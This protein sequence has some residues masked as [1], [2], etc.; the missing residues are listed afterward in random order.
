M[1]DTLTHNPVAAD[2]K[3]RL[4]E[5]SKVFDTKSGPFVALEPMTLDIPEGCFF[6][7]VGPS[8]CGKTTL[9][10]ILAGLEERSGGSLEITAPTKGRPSNSMV[11]QG[12]SLFPWMT[13]FENA[14]YGLRMRRRPAGEIRDVVGHYLQRTGLSRFHESYPHQLSGGM[15]QRVSIARAFAN[16]PDILL[17][18]EHFSALDEQN[19][20]LLQ[21]ELLRIWEETRKTVMFITHSVDEAVTLGDRIMIMTAHPGRSKLIVD[22]PFER[23]RRVLELRAQPAY[24]ELVYSIWGHLRDEVQRAR[25]QDEGSAK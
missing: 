7:I 8:G 24:G 6:M 4:R 10:R 25:A 3:I 15:R 17:M 2:V 14:A 21:E 11:F 19:K 9:L 13:V 12:D 16:D 20:I 22:V 1:S 5:L 23:P 18:D